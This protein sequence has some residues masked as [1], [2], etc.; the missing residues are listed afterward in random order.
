MED[1]FAARRGECLLGERARRLAAQSKKVARKTGLLVLLPTTKILRVIYMKIW[2]AIAAVATI[3]AGVPGVVSAEAGANNIQDLL[4][5]CES[6]DNLDF[7]ICIG[8]MKGVSAVTDLN[9]TA[10]RKG[11]KADIW[12]AD[13]IGVTFGAMQQSFINWAKANPN[14]WGYDG[15]WGATV[16]ISST[17]PCR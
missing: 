7:G 10:I 11:A 3:C 17:F 1:C 16:A 4:D 5:D 13:T 12:A 2:A 14:L 6:A 8:V 9:C 15:A